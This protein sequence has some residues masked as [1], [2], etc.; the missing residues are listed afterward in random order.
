MP[1]PLRVVVASLLLVIAA[2]GL[3]A[4]SGQIALTYLLPPGDS[5]MAT[6]HVAVFVPAVVGTIV[7]ALAAGALLAH[8]VAVIR[9]RTA[10]W[11]WIAAAICTVVA[12]GTPVVVA[13]LDRPTF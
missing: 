4:V 1:Q 7:A 10:P 5:G 3:A 2:L 12:V 13:M 9:R 6:K 8:L 11:S